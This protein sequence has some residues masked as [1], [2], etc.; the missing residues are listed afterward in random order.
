MKARYTQWF[1]IMPGWVYAGL[2]D[3]EPG[4]PREPEEGRR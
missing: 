4:P 3:V 1:F 2:M